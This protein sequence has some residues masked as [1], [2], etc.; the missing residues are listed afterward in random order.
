[1]SRALAGKEGSHGPP[2]QTHLSFQ[3]SRCPDSLCLETTQY[4]D[5]LS[6]LKRV[7]PVK[8]HLKQALNAQG[9]LPCG[10]LPSSQA[11]SIHPMRRGAAPMK[12]LA[13]RCVQ[14][15]AEPICRADIGEEEV[16]TSS[17]GGS[18]A[19]RRGFPTSRVLNSPS[20]P[21][22]TPLLAGRW[23]RPSWWPQGTSG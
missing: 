18:H 12:G 2:S 6:F 9:E 14:E 8:S 4:L 11:R 5:M 10:C 13:I 21:H 7:T 22:Q 19:H 15:P 1:M 23:P 20:Q 17:G 16:V 3:L